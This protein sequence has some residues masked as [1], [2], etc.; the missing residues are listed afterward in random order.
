MQNK[1][2]MIREGK[3]NF[4]FV[5]WRGNVK[6]QKAGQGGHDTYD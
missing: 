1:Q 5:E 4:S 6:E 3:S 2:E